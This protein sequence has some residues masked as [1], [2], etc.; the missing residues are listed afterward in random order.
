[1]LPDTRTARSLWS[2]RLFSSVV[3]VAG[4]LILARSGLPEFRSLPWFWLA[5][6]AIA[7][8]AWLRLP[9]GRTTLSMGS[10]ANFAAALALP[11]Q[12]A[13]LCASLASLI[14]ELAIMRKPVHRAVFNCAGTAITMSATVLVLQVFFRPG[15]ASPVSL[16]S[17]VPLLAAAVTY[18][19][20]NRGLVMTILS[21]DLWTSPR[22]IWLQDF[23]VRR[24]L[25]PTGAAFSLGVLLAHE[26]QSHG[27]AALVLLLFPG[28]FVLEAH[29]RRSA[30][31]A[32]V[33]GS[34]YDADTRSK[35]AA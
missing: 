25:L 3:V 34:P 26:V 21:L 7:E 5:A 19:A 8:A 35:R 16:W 12:Q 29:R 2:V 6:C 28:A 14:V 10:I 33:P 4:G 31:S 13:V 32:S 11:Q 15:G 9:D 20:C 23:G 30:M 24:D 27:P 17:I 22:S 18:Y 1:M